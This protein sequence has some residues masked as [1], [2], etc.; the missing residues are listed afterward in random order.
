MHLSKLGRVIATVVVALFA[1]GLIGLVVSAA[2]RD[3]SGYV[4][5]LENKLKHMDEENLRATAIAPVD[6]YGD[7]WPLAG[8]ICP[9]TPTDDVEK[10]YEVDAKKLGIKGESVPADENF[11]LLLNQDG[12]TKVDHIKTDKV[13][14]CSAGS[15]GPM[16]AR[17]LIPFMKDQHGTWVIPAN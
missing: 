17:T 11:V 1:L 3:D 16:D 7:D 15:P 5:S 10:M 8:I 9:G 12:E 2:N 14:M 6:V 4:G 13:N